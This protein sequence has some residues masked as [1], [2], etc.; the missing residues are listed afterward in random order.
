MPTF[1]VI[2]EERVESAYV[3][4]AESQT[5]AIA[6]VKKIQPENQLNLYEERAGINLVNTSMVKTGRIV[7][8]EYFG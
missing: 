4:E 2:R 7:N 6:K 3:V 1:R 8:V 5:D